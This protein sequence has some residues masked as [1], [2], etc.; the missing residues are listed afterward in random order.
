LLGLLRLNTRNDQKELFEIYDAIDVKQT[1]V[2]VQVSAHIKQD[3]V[4]QL[5]KSVIFNG[6]L[7]GPLTSSPGSRHPN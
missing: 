3:L 7:G 5:L 6:R 4:D 1:G 2:K